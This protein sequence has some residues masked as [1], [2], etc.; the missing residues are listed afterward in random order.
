[1]HITHRCHEKTFLFKFQRDRHAWL[2]WLFEAKKRFGLCVL[3]Y[4]VTSNHIHLLLKDT[5]SDV[6]AR[7]MQ[8][9]AGR[10]GQDYNQRKTRQGAFW[11]DRYHATAVE[12]DEHLQRC[13]VYIDLNMVR[14]GV[15]RHPAAWVHGGYRE[16]QDPPKRY[17]LVDL[18]QL[19]T[20]CGFSSIEEF[21]RAH[22]R[23][24]EHALA[25]EALKRE[26]RWSEAIAVGSRAFVEEVKQ[27]LA[28]KAR[29]RDIENGENGTCEL[30]EPASAYG[31]LFEAEKGVLRRKNG[32]FW[33]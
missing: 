17:A 18:Q 4:V 5:G 9:A 23:W 11:E 1:M 6:I 15:V 14:A 7:S 13:V 26:S 10:T 28:L 3:N 8:L 33:R 25:R 29:H 2:R 12:G 32:V 31:G 16:I 22:H 20:T 27:E 24:V 21:R 19:A 30:R